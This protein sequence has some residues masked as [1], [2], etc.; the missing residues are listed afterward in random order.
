MERRQL[1]VL[2]GSELAIV[3]GA[4]HFRLPIAGAAITGSCRFCPE[5][6]PGIGFGLD[7]RIAICASCVQ[8]GKEL[9]VAEMWFE[10]TRDAAVAAWASSEKTMS[11]DDVR[12]LGE[13]ADMPST[14]TAQEAQH[15]LNAVYRNASRTRSR[16]SEPGPT[17]YECG[18]CRCAQGDAKYLLMAQGGGA[19]ICEV[20]LLEI[21]TAF[22]DALAS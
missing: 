13:A 19:F 11:L 17:R 7:S 16:N 20:C 22:L 10:R 8:R 6:L 4:R 3:L 12:K 2:L 15:V 18:F 1:L 21:G 9:L 5:Q 14:V